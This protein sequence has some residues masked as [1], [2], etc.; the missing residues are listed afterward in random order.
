MHNFNPREEVRADLRGEPRVDDHQVYSPQFRVM[1]QIHDPGRTEAIQETYRLL[2]V[3]VFAAMAGGWLGS[4]SPDVIRF[5]LSV[6]GLIVAMMA[7]NFIPSMTINVARKNPR[8][9]VPYLGL[10]GLVSGL[11]LSPLIFFAM[12]R[13]GAG[14]DTP[15]LVQAALAI[16]AFIFLGVSGYVWKSGTRFKASEGYLS[17]AFWAITAAVVVNYFFLHSG[18]MGIAVSTAIGLF[19]GVGLVM[20]TAQVLND[21]EYRDPVVGALC[22][23]AGLFNIF[24]A[25]LHLL[26]AFGGGR[27]S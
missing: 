20:S 10:F 26:L 19:G 7:L 1:N 23:Y 25:V 18:V 12:I 14:V 5:F 16:T 17:A 21:P 13:S 27:R 3:A 2:A 15:N 11:V 8:L 24:Q 6:P 9:G 22:I 4:R